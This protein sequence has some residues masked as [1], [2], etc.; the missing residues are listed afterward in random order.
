MDMAKHVLN[1]KYIAKKLDQCDA[2]AFKAGSIYNAIDEAGIFPERVTKM[3]I[4]G[5]KAGNLPSMAEKLAQTYEIE[6]DNTLNKISGVAETSF[7]V[8]ISLVVGTILVSVILPLVRIL[9]MIG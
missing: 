8:L 4:F 7:V 1:N 6:V 3:L 2:D 5:V 9:S